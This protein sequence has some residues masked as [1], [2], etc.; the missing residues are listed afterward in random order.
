MQCSL[1]DSEAR[2]AI[3]KSI[4]QASSL[5]LKSDVNFEYFCNDQS[6]NYTG[7]DIKSILVTANMIAVK[8]CLANDPEVWCCRSFDTFQV[9]FFFDKISCF[10]GHRTYPRRF[11]SVKN[12]SSKH[13][14]IH[15]H[16]Y[17]TKMQSNIGLCKLKIHNFF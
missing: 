5:K 14:P 16:R 11:L 3:F 15:D 10:S 2:L 13:L 8:E 1:P 9:F 17:P 6:D 4:A 12:I 7:A